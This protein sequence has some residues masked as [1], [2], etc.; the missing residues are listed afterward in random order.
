MHLSLMWYKLSIY[1]ITLQQTNFYY[2]VII[3][4]IDHRK[5]KITEYKILSLFIEIKQIRISNNNIHTIDSINFVI[6]DNN[7]K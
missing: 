4:S 7:K 1:V 3:K 2:F 5:Q 6:F